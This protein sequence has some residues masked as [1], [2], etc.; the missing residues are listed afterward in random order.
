MQIDGQVAGTLDFSVQHVAT[1][2][3]HLANSFTLS[4]GTLHATFVPLS[5]G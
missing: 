4:G 2:I 3:G 1:D 5:V